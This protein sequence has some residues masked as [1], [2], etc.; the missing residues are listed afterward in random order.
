MAL[1]KLETK[2]DYQSF[3]KDNPKAAIDFFADWCGPCRMIAPAYE[4]T[5][6]LA[7]G[8]RISGKR[9]GSHVISKPY[10]ARII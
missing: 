3:I 2:A 10:L 9:A 6:S 7:L 4:V 1:V 8:C 5:L